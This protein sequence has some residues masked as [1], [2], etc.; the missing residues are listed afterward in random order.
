MCHLHLHDVVH[1]DL[2]SPNILLDTKPKGP[3][4]KT[5]DCMERAPVVRITDFGLSREAPTQPS[6]RMTM[7]L[8]VGTPVWMSP[9]LLDKQAEYSN[10][11]DLYSYAVVLTELLSESQHKSLVVVLLSLL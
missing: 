2:K 4:H 9:E 8:K 3:W 1:R 6:Q 7:N 5:Q 10:K 11:V